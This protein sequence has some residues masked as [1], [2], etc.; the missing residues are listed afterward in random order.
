M[1]YLAN[2]SW[3]WRN[4]NYPNSVGILTQDVKPDGYK[5]SQSSSIRFPITEI[6]MD[7]KG[8]VFDTKGNL[9]Q[10]SN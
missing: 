4:Y 2:K 6:K 7:A 10:K 5:S 3:N 1:D 8:N 9:T